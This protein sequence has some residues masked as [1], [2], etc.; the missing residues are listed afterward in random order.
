MAR[1]DAK[2]VLTLSQVSAEIVR[3]ICVTTVARC[4]QSS[5][6][7]EQTVLKIVTA[8]LKLVPRPDHPRFFDIGGAYFACSVPAEPEEAAVE[9][10]TQLLNLLRWDVAAVIKLRTD[11]LG[12][13]AARRDAQEV[14]WYPQSLPIRATDEPV[15]HALPAETFSFGLWYRIQF[16]A[17]GGETEL[18]NLVPPGL[19]EIAD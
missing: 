14:P 15:G 2:A 13:K 7:P 16:F 10:L 17:P 11:E 5:P 9:R 19:N 8:T 18:A 4:I 1:P 6:R 3:R 12:T